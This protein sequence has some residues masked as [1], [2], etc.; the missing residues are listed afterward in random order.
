MMCARSVIRST[1]ALQSRALGMDL[2]RFRERQ[3]GGHNHRSLL[4]PFRD[5]LE[6][7]LCADFRQ[8]HI[9]NFINR[10]EVTAGPAA[11]GTTELQLMFGL[12]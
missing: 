8:R 1:S 6:Q 12:H 7:K 2:G 9:T 4:G 10:N 11:Q 5:N 3:I